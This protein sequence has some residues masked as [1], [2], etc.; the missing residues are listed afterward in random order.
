MVGLFSLIPAIADAVGVPVVATGGIADGRGT[1]A[2]LLLGASAVQI[3]T[4]FLR[5]PEAAIPPAWADALA[6]TPPE[7]TIIS[8]AFSGRAGRCIETAYA[9]AAASPD[10]PKPAPYPVQRGLTKAMREE[11]VTCNNLGRMQVWAGQ[12][13]MLARA[14]SAAAIVETIGAQLATLL[15]A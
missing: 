10:A 7:G 4:G 1:A 6:T 14:E 13:S 8:R 11:A 15:S 5:C 12:S 2:A 3:G 9:L